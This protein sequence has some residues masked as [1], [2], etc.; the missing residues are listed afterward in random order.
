MLAPGRDALAGRE[1]TLEVGRLEDGLPQ[2]CFDLVFT[3][4]AVHHLDGAGKA[5]LFTRIAK[6]LADGGRFVLADVV[7]PVD[8]RG[9]GDAAL[10]ADRPSE[11]RRRRA[12]LAARR[13][14]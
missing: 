2:G 4:L 7:P 12:A 3:A 1:V 5:E 10:P 13:R 8:G 6:L 9:G 14:A 11:H